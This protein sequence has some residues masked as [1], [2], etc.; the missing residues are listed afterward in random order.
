MKKEY[1]S[2]DYNARNDIRLVRLQMKY[3]L[4]GLGAFWCIVEMLY[5]EG[6]CLLIEEYERITFE[7]RTDYEMVKS[8][9]EAF[10]LF[11]NDGIKFWSESALERLKER[12]KKSDKAR[13]SI[14]KR[15]NKHERNT[16]VLQPLY[17]PNTNIKVKVKEKIYKESIVK[18]NFTPPT[19]QE[20]IEYFNQNGYTSQSADKF[21]KY[22]ETG[23]WTDSKGS[24]IK[25][26][27]QK[28]QA[29]WFKPENKAQKEPE[30]RLKGWQP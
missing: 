17:E 8:V 10:D 5:E 15:W 7:L 16:N 24:K 6:G 1:F 20:V 30:G 13:E 26:W 4:A 28:A 23:D 3:G 25:N 18:K 21:F 12:A 19:L 9:I 11:K 29:V 22:Y 14:S 2:H 27:K